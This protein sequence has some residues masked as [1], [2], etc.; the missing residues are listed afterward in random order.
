M[1]KKKDRELRLA[2]H[3]IGLQLLVHSDSAETWKSY[4]TFLGGPDTFFATSK[5]VS[6]GKIRIPFAGKGI[7]VDTLKPLHRYSVKVHNSIEEYDIVEAVIVDHSCRNSATEAILTGEELYHTAKPIEVR[8]GHDDGEV[9][10]K[11]MSKFAK[12]IE[13]KFSWSVS[14][15]APEKSVRTFVFAIV[16][17]DDIEELTRRLLR[18]KP[19]PEKDKYQIS[20]FLHKPGK[21][22]IYQSYPEIDYSEIPHFNTGTFP[23]HLLAFEHKELFEWLDSGSIPSNPSKIYPVIKGHRKHIQYVS[24]LQIIDWEMKVLESR[25]TDLLESIPEQKPESITDREHR[26]EELTHI[27]EDSAFY[28][29]SH[30]LAKDYIIRERHRDYDEDYE[31]PDL[32]KET[33]ERGLD[34]LG[35][36]L[37]ILDQTVQNRM[38]LEDMTINRHREERQER[39]ANAF[40]ALS[41]MI[42][43]LF[44]FEI[45]ATFWSWYLTPEYL[46]AWIPWVSVILSPLVLIYW[47]TRKMRDALPE[48]EKGSQD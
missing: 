18:P 21:W 7:K 8:I 11:L 23:F 34:I 10:N 19:A 38:T 42:G 35:E 36:R 26:L 31:E 44:I 1:A 47:A 3:E 12:I 40:N 24:R 16:I 37:Q 5:Y 33:I 13:S 2:V 9:R 20:Q 27:K 22:S 32:K 14:F 41:L 46:F 28:R 39:T 17:V 48:L 45:L 43:V 4:F 29:S 25:C 15:N 30:L 6:S